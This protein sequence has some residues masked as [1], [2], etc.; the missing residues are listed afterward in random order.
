[1]DHLPFSWKALDPF[2]KINTFDE[3]RNLW[4]KRLRICFNLN[5]LHSGR[6]K[7]RV[8][9]LITGNKKWNSK[10]ISWIAN[11]KDSFLLRPT[12]WISLYC[13]PLVFNDLFAVTLKMMLLKIAISFLNCL[14]LTQ[15]L[16]N[17]LGRMFSTF[18]SN[19][20]MAL[21]GWSNS[22]H[23]SSLIHNNWLPRLI[24]RFILLF[25]VTLYL[26]ELI[27]SI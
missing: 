1:M 2:V 4:F 6:E 15:N 8:S 13:V 20:L 12:H 5:L 22:V 14:I 16:F 3:K 23:H 26:L 10:M 24:C 17:R 19:S 11:L 9:G 25:V 7:E 18:Y 27:N 21:T